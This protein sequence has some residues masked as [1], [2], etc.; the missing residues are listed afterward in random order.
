[1]T[2]KSSGAALIT[3][4]WSR[5]LINTSE[6]KTAVNVHLILCLCPLCWLRDPRR[7]QAV[8]QHQ[9]RWNEAVQQHVQ[10]VLAALGGIKT[11][12]LCYHRQGRQKYD[13]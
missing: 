5:V 13:D 2:L 10:T 1:M 3:Q 4:H 11:L 7:K 12:F 9:D 8:G 6:K